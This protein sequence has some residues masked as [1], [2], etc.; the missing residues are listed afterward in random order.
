MANVN[1]QICYAKTNSSKWLHEKVCSYC[2]LTLLS[3]NASYHTVNAPGFASTGL[4]DVNYYPIYNVNI[5]CTIYPWFTSYNV[6]ANVLWVSQKTDKNRKDHSKILEN[7]WKIAVRK[8]H[9]SIN[10]GL[11]LSH[12]RSNIMPILAKCLVLAG[13][14]QYP[15]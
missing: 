5:W 13:M 3:I 1:L 14:L 7:N 9:F 11:V 8:I 15:C 4:I 2:C 6:L 10:V 12:H